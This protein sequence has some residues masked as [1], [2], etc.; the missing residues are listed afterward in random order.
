MTGSGVSTD[1]GPV[2]G[3]WEV[4]NRNRDYFHFVHAFEY[5]GSVRVTERPPARCPNGHHLGPHK[6]LVGWYPCLCSS[7]HTGHRTYYCRTCG[8][9]VW[10]PPC[11][12]LQK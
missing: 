7:G 11:R 9:E 2:D 5:S 8:A 12:I 10:R 3:G 1:S 6:V 4:S